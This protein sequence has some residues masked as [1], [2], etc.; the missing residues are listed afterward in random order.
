MDGPF[1]QQQ[2]GT[3]DIEWVKLFGQHKSLV[4][5]GNLRLLAFIA[6]QTLHSVIGYIYC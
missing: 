1:E 6:S 2:F 5:P 3:A 4:V